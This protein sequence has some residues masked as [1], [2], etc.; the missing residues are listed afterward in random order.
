MGRFVI[1]RNSAI[2]TGRRWQGAISDANKTIASLR[3]H[4]EAFGEI[5]TKHA[6]SMANFQ[7]ELDKKDSRISTLQEEVV[8]LKRECAEA[9]EEIVVSLLLLIWLLQYIHI[10]TQSII[11][12]TIKESSAC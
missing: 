3:G 2:E 5:T 7:V 11:H 6:N 9:T 10:L 8:S 1:E 4:L 12:L